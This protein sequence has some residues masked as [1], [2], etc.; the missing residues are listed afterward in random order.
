MNPKPVTAAHVSGMNRNGP[1]SLASRIPATLRTRSTGKPD[2]VIR[3]IRHRPITVSTTNNRHGRRSEQKRPLIARIQDPRHA[4]DEEHRQAGQRDQSD[5]TQA[6][7]GLDDKQP[8]R[9]QWTDKEKFERLAL[10]KLG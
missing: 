5:P 1:T 3:V 2:N 4:Q 8:P 6:N 10:G 7:H 9:P